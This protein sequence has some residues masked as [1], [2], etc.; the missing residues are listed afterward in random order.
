MWSTTQLLAARAPPRGAQPAAPRCRAPRRPAAARAAAAPPRHVELLA[1]LC[2]L[3][4]AALTAWAAD[5]RARLSL[6]FLGWVAER[7]E[8]EGEGGAAERAALDALGGRLMALR[9]GFEPASA[10]ALQA[11]FARAAAEAAERR[12][13]DDG[14]AAGGDLPA[15]AP[16]ARAAAAA[17]GLGPAALVAVQAQAEALEAVV[18]ASR[19]RSL[20]EVLGRARVDAPGQAARLAGADAAGRILEVLLGVEGRAARAALLPDAFAPP[21]EGVGD[22]FG[23]EEQLSTTSLRLLQAVD[24]WL[25][26]L[27]GGG[28][29]AGR[30]ALGG[31]AGGAPTGPA[32]R[33]ALEELRE[34][35]A[36]FSWDAE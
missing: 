33:R 19:A 16:A 7:G 28:A 10:A 27:E 24:L 9:E 20:T 15:L 23:E 21:A 22:A 5:N 8:A 6:D 31:G 11:G 36:A 4:A 25:A 29:A 30:L 13:A 2:A 18:G 1:E 12:G 35:V 17:L 32:L 3:D 26:R 14:A 34:D